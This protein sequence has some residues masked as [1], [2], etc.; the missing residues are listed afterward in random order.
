MKY[1]SKFLFCSSTLLMASNALAASGAREDNSNVFVW[2]FLG[3]C[4]FIVVMQL[5]PAVMMI[6]G[7]AKGVSKERDLQSVTEKAEN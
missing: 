1:L 7:F 6:F 5:L 3:M 2:I 4:A